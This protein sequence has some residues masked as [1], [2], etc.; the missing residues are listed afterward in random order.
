MTGIKL[1]PRA[2]ASTATWL[3][4]AVAGN[5]IAGIGRSRSGAHPR[6]LVIGRSPLV[7]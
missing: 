1:W 5:G 7:V 2:P 6:S 3:L 4:L